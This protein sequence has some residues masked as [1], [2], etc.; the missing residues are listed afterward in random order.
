MKVVEL[1]HLITKYNLEEKGFDSLYYHGKKIGVFGADKFELGVWV[2]ILQHTHENWNVN[3]IE[4]ALIAKIKEVKE[5]E[6]KA[7]IEKINKDFE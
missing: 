5:N 1:A 3:E 2:L 7:K 4:E 6:I